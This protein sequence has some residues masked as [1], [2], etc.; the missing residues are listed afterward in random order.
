MSRSNR[1]MIFPD[2]VLGRSLV[3]T[4]L[5]GLAMGPMVWATWSRSSTSRLSSPSHTRS[6]TKAAMA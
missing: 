1:R 5:R 6:V 3:K 2:R 4:M